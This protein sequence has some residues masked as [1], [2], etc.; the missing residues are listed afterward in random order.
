MLLAT[1]IVWLVLRSVT[2]ELSE[3]LLFGLAHI[4]VGLI[5]AHATEHTMKLVYVAETTN[6]NAAA[7]AAA[8]LAAA[9]S[10]QPSAA[11]A[12]KY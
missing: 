11:P 2:G 6:R 5:S 4:F 9:A 3:L 12:L 7:I 8:Q 1:A 10:A